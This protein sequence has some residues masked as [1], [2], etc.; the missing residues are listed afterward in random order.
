M[1]GDPALLFDSEERLSRVNA[2][3][4]EPVELARGRGEESS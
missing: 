3:A 4:R 2:I 1:D